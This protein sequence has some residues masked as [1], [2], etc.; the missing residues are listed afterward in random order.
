MILKVEKRQENTSN[1]LTSVTSSAEP[2]FIQQEYKLPELNDYL[3]DKSYLYNAVSPTDLDRETFDIV[4]KIHNIQS[5]LQ[6]AQDTN[7]SLPH[8]FRWF[9][10]MS[11]YTAEE[12]LHFPKNLKHLGVKSR[13]SQDSIAEINHRVRTQTKRFSLYQCSFKLLKH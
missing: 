1:S 3:S 6:N 8:F 5:N 9:R 12:R 4:V 2:I 11:S 13:E 7:P 10:N